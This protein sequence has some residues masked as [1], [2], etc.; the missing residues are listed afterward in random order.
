MKEL[1]KHVNNYIKHCNWKDIAILK[2][3]LCSLGVMIGI[4]VPKEKKKPIFIIAFLT[5]IIT[6][7]PTMI[8]FIKCILSKKKKPLCKCK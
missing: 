3:C 7:I 6:Y 2:A 8:K 5:Y 4:V 1:I